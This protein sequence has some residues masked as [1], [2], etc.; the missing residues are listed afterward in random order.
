MNQNT[1]G[2]TGTAQTGNAAHGGTRIKINIKNGIEAWFDVDDV[3]L[4]VWG[5]TWT[6]RE[7]ITVCQ[8]E[9]K[10]V[11]SSKRSWRLKTPHAFEH[12]GQHYLVALSVG[13]GGAGVELYRNGVLID[14]DHINTSG[15]HI[16]P[17]TGKLD[18]KHALKSLALPLVIG[19]VVGV[20]FGYL[21]GLAFK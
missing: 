20:G 4:H 15:I 13:F 16:D 8:G 12:N 2:Q 5:S 3:T 17:A 11:V 1:Q 19:L 7:V 10:R 14:S 18:W 6:G 21:A 9:Q